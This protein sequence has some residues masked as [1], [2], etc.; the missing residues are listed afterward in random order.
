MPNA[1]VCRMKRWNDRMNG[2]PREAL[3][4]ALTLLC[5]AAFFFALPY[6]WPFLL[7]L[8]FSA[9]LN[10][11]VGALE[12]GFGKVKI[13]RSVGTLL[14]MLVLFGVV[15]WIAAAV[16]G[17]LARELVALLRQA[18]QW[19]SWVSDTALPY[20]RGLYDE[21]QSVLPPEAPDMIGS[22]LS[23]LGQ[24]LLRLAGTLS[25]ALTG[26]AWST[27][28]SIPSALLSAV[29]T[30]MG[31]Y[32]LTADRARILAA[33]RRLL[34]VELRGRLSE[35]RQNLFR[36]L[37][38]QMKSQLAVSMLGMAF[39][40]LA[41]AI[42]R[43]PYG[44]LLG[45]SIGLAD[46]LPVV[47]AGLFLIPWS[48]VSFLAG[49]TRDGVFL[50]CAYVGVVV[51]RQVAEPRIVGKNLGLHPLLT[52]VAIYAGYRLLGAA[53]LLAGPVLLNVLK[54]VLEADRRAREKR[55]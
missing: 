21:Y 48:L 24:S 10:A 35:I 37:F 14:M 7:A 33:F 28:T 18:P 31:T 46:A 9:L 54:A 13:K 53:G 23:G 44:L 2:L 29:L 49:Q 52:M 16:V 36:T 4:C 34:P 30:V 17:R 26:G 43:I 15:G 27:A 45:V 32:Y 1:L 39:L 8:G 19:I 3:L 25:A 6:F 12:R 47:G 50:A 42:Y 41:F 51:I 22:A 20:L 38:L 55:P 40:T 5:A 11:P